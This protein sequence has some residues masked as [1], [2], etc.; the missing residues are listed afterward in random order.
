[1]A[2]QGDRRASERRQLLSQR[3]RSRRRGLGLTQ[4][5]VVTR[6]ARL[7][8]PTS[9]RA[10]SSIERGAGLNVSKLPELALALECSVTYLLG[11]T[12]E[13]RRWHPDTEDAVV[14]DPP[15]RSG[16][17]AHRGVPTGRMRPP[18]LGPDVPDL[19]GLGTRGA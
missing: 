7:E 9:N 19:T 11:L 15:G 10:L 13:P 8:Q 12:D 4:Q 14:G 17:A 3:I 2:G 5:Q 6:L 18:I 1:M 16:P